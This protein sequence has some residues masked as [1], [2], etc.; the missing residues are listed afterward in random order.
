MM[1]DEHQNESRHQGAFVLPHGAALV[2]DPHDPRK[3]RTYRDC[4]QDAG[5]RGY[6]DHTSVCPCNP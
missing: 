6:K 5:A 3:R 1:P 4:Q 2:L